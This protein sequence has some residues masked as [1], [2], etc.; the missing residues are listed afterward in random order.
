MAYFINVLS[1]LQ[2]PNVDQLKVCGQLRSNPQLTLLTSRI[3]FNG[4]ANWLVNR[5]G[6][7][8]HRNT[9][10]IKTTSSLLGWQSDRSTTRFQVSQ[11]TSSSLHIRPTQLSGL[12]VACAVIAIVVIKSCWHIG[13]IPVSYTH[14]DVYKRQM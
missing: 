12:D 9:H 3:E 14:L 10:T 5:K 4:P 7:Q 8:K 6:R 11:F 13:L 1:V 2:T